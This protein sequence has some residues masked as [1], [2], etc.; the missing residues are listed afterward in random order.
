MTH[1]P[2]NTL[3]APTMTDQALIQ[4]I[5]DGNIGGICIDTNILLSEG[6]RSFESIRMHTLSQKV[7]DDILLLIPDIL[8]GEML[9]Y[10]V[11]RH[12]DRLKD[13]KCA[14]KKLERHGIEAET[15][16]AIRLHE[17]C[18]EYAA[19]RELR[20]FKDRTCHEVLP[21]SSYVCVDTLIKMYFD[22]SAP[23]ATARDKKS[24]FPDAFALL[25]LNEWATQ[26]GTSVICVSTDG[27]WKDYCDASDSRLI[28]VDTLT[29]VLNAITRAGDINQANFETFHTTLSRFAEYDSQFRQSL[30][31]RLQDILDNASIDIEA[32]SYHRCESYSEGAKILSYDLHSPAYGVSVITLDAEEAEASL[33]ITL[34][35]EFHA[36]VT[37]HVFD[38]VDRMEMPLA[39]QSFIQTHNVDVEAILQLSIIDSDNGHKVDI[40]DVEC[41]MLDNLYI[42]FGEVE[43]DLHDPT[44]R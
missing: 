11:G 27:G 13:I 36:D 15:M 40:E 22:E 39:S 44:G 4:K 6:Q 16:E 20:A 28:Y 2:D 17:F 31:S 33:A 5:I 7:S 41:A 43:L 12:T 35:I 9:K 29:D 34:E 3:T 32:S 23:F 10:C 21:A 37:F 38:S 42:D 24:E 14:I 26:K 8:E 19:R 1:R 25:T 18:P 30:I